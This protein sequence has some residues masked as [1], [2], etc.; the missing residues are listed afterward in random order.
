MLHYTE[1]V[2]KIILLNDS[3]IIFSKFFSD[4]LVN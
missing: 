4:K 3:I 2:N 1:N